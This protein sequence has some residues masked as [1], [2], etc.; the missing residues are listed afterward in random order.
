MRMTAFGRYDART[1][2][3][4]LLEWR[5]VQPNQQRASP[6]FKG[7]D[8][9][10]LVS[11]FTMYRYDASYALDVRAAHPA[12]F[13]LIKPVDPTDPAVA[14]T[15]AGWAPPMVQSGAKSPGICRQGTIVGAL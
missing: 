10:L 14:V 12:R 3:G 15:I 5:L 4:R 1:G 9:A 11:P 6:V 2:A 7:A 13:G 8:G